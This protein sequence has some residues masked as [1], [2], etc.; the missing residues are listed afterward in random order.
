[1][2]QAKKVDIADVID[3]QTNWFFSISTAVLCG[4]VLLVDGFDNQAIN[5]TSAAIIRDWQVDRVLF[6]PVFWANILGW[7]TGSLV[8]SMIADQIGRRNAT[9]LA[10]F[11]FSLFTYLIAYATNLWELVGLKF[12]SSLGV[13]GAMPMAI[14]LI[15]DYTPSKRRGLMIT[16]LYLGY[17]AGSSGGGFLAAELIL[18]QGWQSIFQIGGIVGLAVT[19]A[20]LF[21]L[22]ESVRYLLVQGAPQEKIRTYVRRMKPAIPIDA[23]TEYFIRETK[24]QKGVP[25][26][27]LFQDGRT[28]MTFFL[29]FA[30]GFSF[31][32]HFFI[33][34]WLPILLSDYMPL[35]QVNRVKAMFQ[36]GAGFGFIFG[37]LIDRY[38]VP[39]VTWTKLFG[40]IPVALIGVIL[41]LQAGAGTLTLIT[42]ASGIF[43]LGGTIGLN[44]ISSMIY[45]TFIRSTGSGAAF[46]AARVGALLG[47]SLGALLIWLNVPVPWMF[48]IGAVPMILSGLCAFGLSKTVDVL[49]TRK[50]PHLAPAAS[51]DEPVVDRGHAPARP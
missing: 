1:M 9:I 17:T 50:D 14:A 15:A 46:A 6:T 13:G 29:W 22:P 35:D 36:M 11:L 45:P 47:P 43:V 42:L 33:S 20:L 7:M 5:Y 16:L 26:K 12:L 31:V 41:V 18:T 28:A 19:A 23:D 44:A 38:G 4:V 10:T 49:Y 32:T 21:T 51:S 24:K 48:V 2:A 37:W 40:A 25:L 39:V 27:F 8:F 3:S 30:L 34:N